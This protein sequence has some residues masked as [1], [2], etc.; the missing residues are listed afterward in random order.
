MCT[1]LWLHM[2]SEKTLFLDVGVPQGYVLSVF[3]FFKALI[4]VHS[5]FAA[6]KSFYVYVDF[7]AALN[8]VATIGFGL[9]LF[10]VSFGVW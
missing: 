9:L 8:F 6:R 4:Q 10:G 5:L 3:P 1:K 2:S 7:M